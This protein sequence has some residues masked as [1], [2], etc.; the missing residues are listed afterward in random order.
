MITHAEQIH[1]L[2]SNIEEQ[3]VEGAEGH[4][5]RVI[6]NLARYTTNLIEEK[7]YRSFD[8]LKY[9]WK[10]KHSLFGDDV[11]SLCGKKHIRE[12]CIVEEQETGRQIIVGNNCVFTYIE[13]ETDVGEGEYLTGDDKKVFLKSRMTEAKHRYFKAKFQRTYSPTLLQEWLDAYTYR[14][15]SR[16]SFK[17]RVRRMIDKKGYLTGKTHDM[18][19]DMFPDNTALAERVNDT[20]EYTALKKKEE[21]ERKERARIERLKNEAEAREFVIVADSMRPRID[22]DYFLD[23]ATFD[24]MKSRVRNILSNGWTLYGPNRDFYTLVYNLKDGID[25]FKNELLESIT[26]TDNLNDW[27]KGFL[28][29]IKEQIGRGKVLTTRQEDCLKKIAKKVG[30]NDTMASE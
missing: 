8:D 22:P 21:A 3:M 30:V 26:T 17:R 29:S 24:V 1:T 13:I 4:Q 11:C 2:P 9:D 23:K 27:E 10:Y 15:R 7:G 5:K 28:I 18:F 25:P 20:R 12:L 14:S 6:L 16:A 19:V